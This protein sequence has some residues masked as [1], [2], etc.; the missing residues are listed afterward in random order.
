MDS[1]L[2]LKG[3]LRN[4]TTLPVNVVLSEQK[5]WKGK[6]KAVLCAIL[7]VALTTGQKKRND[8][9]KAKGLLVAEHNYEKER[10]LQAEALLVPECNREKEHRL[11]AEAFVAAERDAPWRLQAELQ[12]VYEREKKSWKQLQD[13]ESGPFTE[14]RSHNSDF[15][16]PN[17]GVGRQLH[18]AG[19]SS[20]GD[21][22]VT[23]QPLIKVETVYDGQGQ[24]TY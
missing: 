17:E 1:M 11:Q 21:E 16:V 6:G 10:R 4:T 22:E 13:L 15:F 9:K 2:W 20:S 14:I 19:G 7:G 12:D 3:A 5:V 8:N 23:L 18:C 24:Q